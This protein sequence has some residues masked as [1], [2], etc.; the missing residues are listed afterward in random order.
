LDE[1]RR[2]AQQAFAAAKHISYDSRRAR[3][4]PRRHRGPARGTQIKLL[5]LP[6]KVLA[7]ARGVIDENIRARVFA[8]HIASHRYIPNASQ[9]FQIRNHKDTI[10]VIARK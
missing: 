10:L 4:Q 2:V 9:S 5:T 7:A 6:S 3:S 8:C 1:A